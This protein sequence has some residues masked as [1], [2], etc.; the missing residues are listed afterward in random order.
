[1]KGRTAILILLGIL[2]VLG[3]VI[4]IIIVQ[5]FY[6]QPFIPPSTL[7]AM[8]SLTPQGSETP[9]T[10]TP[11]R[12]VTATQE[13][14]PIT[15][16]P[17]AS[18]ELLNTPGPTSTPGPLKEVCG[19]TGSYVMLAILTDITNPDT[20]LDGAI[21][22]RI[23]HVNFSQERIVVYALPPSLILPSPNL[24]SYG[25][26]NATLS[27]AFDTVYSVERSNADAVSMA[28]NAVAQMINESLGILVSHYVV[29]DTA[30]FEKYANDKGSMDVKISGTFVTNGFDMQRGWQ[31][32]D[33]TLIRQYMTY[34]TGDKTA[35]WDRVLRQNDVIN[36]FRQ[37]AKTQDPAAFI[38]NFT[39]KA[40]DGF[41]T[42]LDMGQLKQ[43]VCL[44]NTM[45]SVRFRYYSLPQ[46]RL[47]F[48]EDGTM[49]INDQE[50]VK[51]NIA[52]SL[53]ST[54]E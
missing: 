32:L 19:A 41:A 15:P 27:N 20:D 23:I 2:I 3:T 33:G 37:E 17:L 1:M 51:A 31:K 53:G 10:I 14:T 9:G 39:T 45:E 28:A 21:G 43:L 44:A 4:G 24:V 42:D 25:Y 8:M 46:S 18:P 47:N 54:G 29:I 36:S 7:A 30:T 34:K 26:P 16:I 5:L 22:Y 49:S 11:Q 12:I 40:E 35:E 50:S 13:T 38:A 48:F 52:N 6:R